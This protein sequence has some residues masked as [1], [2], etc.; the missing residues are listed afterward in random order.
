VAPERWDLP[1]RPPEDALPTI[2]DAYR[3]TQ[4]QLGGDL[5]LLHEGMNLQLRVVRDSYPSKFRTYP[6]AAGLLPWSRAFL[7][8]SDAATAVTRASYGSAAPLARMAC[9]CLA[10]AHQAHTEEQPAFQEWL[11]GALRPD[12]RHHATDIT[13]GQFMAGSTLVS[14]V[15]LGAV[16]RAA[17]EFARPHFGI[18]VAVVA[19][20][21]NQQRLAVTFADQT[22]HFGWAQLTLGWLLTL[23][24]VQFRLAR[25]D[26]APYHI[27]DELRA[28][29]TGW[30]ARARRLLDAPDRCRIEEVMDG[31]TRRWLIHNFRRQSGGAPKRLLL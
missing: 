13:I 16:Y 31:L 21:S 8:L 10:A 17:S 30:S 15:N 4:F 26:G 29:A 9:E 6:L 27:T 25:V 3:Q 22:F 11:A 19:S 1:G 20:E 14:E 2:Q 12:E 7:A 24:D 23:C 18:S 5:R 28:A